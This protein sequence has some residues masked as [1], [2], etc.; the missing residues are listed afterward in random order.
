MTKMQAA[1][2]IFSQAICANIEMQGM[3]AANEERKRLGVIPMYS[4]SDFYNLIEKYSIHHNGAI[5]M[6]N[7]TE[8]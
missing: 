1:A 4:E 3:R 7:N 8:D 2:Y 5:G 6:F